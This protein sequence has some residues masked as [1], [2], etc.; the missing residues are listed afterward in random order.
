MILR[1]AALA[2][3]VLL[4]V[5]PKRFSG[6]FQRGKEVTTV[7]FCIYD[8]LLGRILLSDTHLYCFLLPGPNLACGSKPGLNVLIQLRFPEERDGA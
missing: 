8:P 4:P 6:L 2:Y 3:W 1:W 5:T 7:T